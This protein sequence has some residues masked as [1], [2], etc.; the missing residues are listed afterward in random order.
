MPICVN[1][2]GSRLTWPDDQA[3]CRPFPS[4]L[5]GFVAYSVLK[6]KTAK[7]ENCENYAAYRNFAPWNGELPGLHGI[8]GQLSDRLG[9]L[10]FSLGLCQIFLSANPFVLR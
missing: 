8:G 4:C 10:V 1:W 2:P 6:L 3:E 5:L 9:R 7:T